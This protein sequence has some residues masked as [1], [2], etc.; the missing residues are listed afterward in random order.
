MSDFKQILTSFIKTP[1]L[2]ELKCNKH[3]TGKNEVKIH[4]F[5]THI[6]SQYYDLAQPKKKNHR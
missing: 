2:F 6:R 3:R 4:L 5:S 1:V